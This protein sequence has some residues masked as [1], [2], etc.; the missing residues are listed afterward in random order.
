ML[1]QMCEK[2]EVINETEGYPEMC[3]SC[4]KEWQEDAKKF[5]ELRKVGHTRH[6]A[7]RILWGD[8]ECECKNEEG[9]IKSE[10]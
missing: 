1:C 2:N 8:G 7:C 9:G 4:I 6:C 5:R 3:E 10:T